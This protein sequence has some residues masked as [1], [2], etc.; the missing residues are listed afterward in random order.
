MLGML[1]IKKLVSNFLTKAVTIKMSASSWF[2]K[3]KFTNY[4]DRINGERNMFDSCQFK[5]S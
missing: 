2:I 5:E 1:F 3:E 4:F